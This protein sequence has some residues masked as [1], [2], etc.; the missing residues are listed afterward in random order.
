M[1]QS[2]LEDLIIS[3]VESLQGCKATELATEIARESL[4]QVEADMIVNVIYILIEEQRL[5]EIEYELPSMP[6]RT[7]SFLLPNGTKIRSL[8]FC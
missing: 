1:L 4:G 8:E 7:K 6:D 2:Q 5:I 3:K